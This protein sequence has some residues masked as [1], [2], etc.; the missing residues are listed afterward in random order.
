M[1]VSLP[2]ILVLGS[3]LPLA[4]SSSDQD[5]FRTWK[6][7]EL[8]GAHDFDQLLEDCRAGGGRKNQA[9]CTE[10]SV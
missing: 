9:K 3:L 2:L 8:D 5:F 6:N 1:R 4:F 10:V 7:V